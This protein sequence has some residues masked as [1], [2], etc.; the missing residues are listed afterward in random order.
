MEET[1][2]G[3]IRFRIRPVTSSD[4]DLRAVDRRHGAARPEASDRSRTT[5]PPI[6]DAT[7]CSTSSHGLMASP[8]GSGSPGHGRGASPIPFWKPSSAL[9]EHIVARAPDRPFS[10]RSPTMPEARPHGLP[11]RGVRGSCRRFGLPHQPRLHRGRPRAAV[12]V[13]PG[14]RQRPS[15]EPAGVEIVTRE[16]RPDLVPGMYEVALDAVPDIPG[17]EGDDRAASKIGTPS[18]SSARTIVPRPASSRSIGRGRRLRDAPG[19]RGRH[20]LPRRHAGETC[21]ATTRHRPGADPP[22]IEA[23]QDGRLRAPPLRD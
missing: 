19:I 9:G 13:G 2:H 23:A 7:R 5:G 17:S 3:A 22:Q 1:G 16:Q 8:W 20:R 18:R 10:E 14:T 21:V 15:S 12:R 6:H 4:D 11:V